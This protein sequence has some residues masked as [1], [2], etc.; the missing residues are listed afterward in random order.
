MVLRSDETGFGGFT[1]LQDTDAFCYGIDAVLLADAARCGTQERVAD[2]GT[3]NGIVPL[4][5]EA[6]YSPREIIGVELQPEMAS[7]AA[8]NARRNRLDRKLFFVNCDVLDIRSHFAS[9]SFDVVCCNPPY[10]EQ[11][12]GTSGPAGP[13]QLARHESS[14]GLS[15]FIDAA[16]WLLKTGGRFVLIHRP[17]RLVDILCFCRTKGIEPRALRFVSPHAGEE[18]NL[19]LVTAVKGAGKELKILPTLAVRNPDGSFT[20]EVLN[21]YEQKKR[22]SP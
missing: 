17:A 18:P 2:L 5:L 9:S 13:K 20:E 21:I 1:V 10:V 11:G 7:L 4:I 3:G 22:T 6:K 14:A 19:V 15:D 8:E 16:A 12:S